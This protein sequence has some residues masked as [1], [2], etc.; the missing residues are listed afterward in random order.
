MQNCNYCN[1]TGI[2]IRQSFGGAIKDQDCIACNGSGEKK[3]ETKKNGVEENSKYALNP[4][5]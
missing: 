1:G 2:D 5:F 4:F 3:E